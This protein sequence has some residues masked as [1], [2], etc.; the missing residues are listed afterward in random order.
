MC[1]KYQGTLSM[2][3]EYSESNVKLVRWPTVPACYL[4]FALGLSMGLLAGCGGG[5]GGTSYTVMSD[6]AVFQFPLDLEESNFRLASQN[7]DRLRPQ[8]RLLAVAE[9]GGA[10]EE[11]IS[12]SPDSLEFGLSVEDSSGV[13][14]FVPENPAEVQKLFDDYGNANLEIFWCFDSAGVE[15]DVPCAADQLL[16]GLSRYQYRTNIDNETGESVVTANF[17]EPFLEIELSDVNG[18]GIS[19]LGELNSDVAVPGAGFAEGQENGFEIFTTEEIDESTGPLVVPRLAGCDLI[20]NQWNVLEPMLIDID[21]T[22]SSW[23]VS[24]S[25]DDGALCVAIDFPE[26]FDRFVT[27]SVGTVGLGTPS[28]ILDTTLP[29]AQITGLEVNQ[30]V[31]VALAV[32]GAGFEQNQNLLFEITQ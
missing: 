31:G 12:G 24:F 5:G 25:D 32:D 20:T 16:L 14:S 28:T 8:A 17:S 19:E 18:N 2:E 7:S 27:V 15:A 22:L 23:S 21:D 3:S 11:Q 30:V 13:T 9:G 4:K 1:V 29:V 6:T 10:L 26:G